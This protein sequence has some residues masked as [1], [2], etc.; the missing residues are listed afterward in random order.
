MTFRVGII[1]AGAHG[2]RYV[3]HGSQD[4]PGMNVTALCRRDSHRG[5]QLADKHDVRYHREA[6]ALIADPDVDGVV[7]CTPPSSHFK[8]AEQVIQSDK[9]LLLE[10]PMTGTLAEAEQLVKLDQ[11]AGQPL[12]L[13]QALRWNPVL[14]KV[15]GLWPQ[16]GRV[17]HVRLAQRLEPTTLAWQQDAA[18]TVGGSV[19]LTGVHIFDLARW[20]TGAE[21]TAV[22][23]RQAQILNPIVEDFFL[24]RGVL[25]DGCLV[26]LE[27]SKYTQ[28]RAC[29]L[30]AVG[31]NGQIFADYLKGG[32]TLRCGQVE[33]KFEVSAA[34]PTLPALLNDWMAAV[35][36]KFAPPVTVQDGLATLHVADACYRSAEAGREITLQKVIN[37]L[38]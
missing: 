4:V 33:E 23:S 16:L 10:K 18:Q 31:E 32:V 17:H 15:R 13:G 2:E 25:S 29:W 20:L 35:R 6:S 11:A 38:Q 36:G 9:P 5:Q 27:V 22:D 28:S 7:V 30:E 1:G 26:S 21:F 12:M 24:A 8:I 37:R 34:V 14:L 3:R 19:L